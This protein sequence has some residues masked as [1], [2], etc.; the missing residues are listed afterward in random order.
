MDF[1]DRLAPDKADNLLTKRNKRLWPNTTELIG[2]EFELE[3]ISEG[4]FDPAYARGLHAW[5]LG[6]M[7]QIDP[8][9]AKRMH[10]RPDDKGFTISRLRGGLVE[11]DQGFWVRQGETLY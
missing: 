6:Q 3:A 1:P 8:D 7:R 2:L 5:L 4:I 11:T 9:L 10:D